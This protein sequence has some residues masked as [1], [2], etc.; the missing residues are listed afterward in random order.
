MYE[1]LI[2]EIKFKFTTSSGPGGQS[3]NR[4]ST[5]VEL[6]FDVERSNL[7]SP[8][9][10]IIIITKLYSKINSNCELT[11]FCDE[12]RSQKTNRDIAVTKFLELIKDALKPAK[13]RKQTRPSRASKEKR[14]KDKKIKSEKK[15]LRKNDPE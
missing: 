1:R 7:L 12:T 6:R 2:D 14:L 11:L 3:V 10:K 4:V 8:D 9:E 13:K 5:K 15:N